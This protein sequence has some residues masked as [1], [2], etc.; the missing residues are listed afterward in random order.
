MSQLLP[1][2]PWQTVSMDIYSYEGKE[3]L[4]LVDHYYEI[5][6]LSDLHHQSTHLSQAA[7]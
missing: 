5:D 2:R 1:T 4:I 3:F 6:Q 7:E